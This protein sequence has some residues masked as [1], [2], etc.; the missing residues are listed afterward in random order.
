V[1]SQPQREGG[2]Q[3]YAIPDSV[4]AGIPLSPTGAGHIDTWGILRCP[5]QESGWP[6]I[7]PVSDKI[8]FTHDY[9]GGLAIIVSDAEVHDRWTWS[10]YFPGNPLEG[11]LPDVTCWM[12][13]RQ[14]GEPGNPTGDV[15]L[16]TNCTPSGQLTY[17]QTYPSGC[18]CGFGYG[19]EVPV[20]GWPPQFELG[21]WT[22]VVDYTDPYG[23]TT[24]AVVQDNMYMM[25]TPAVLLIHG[26]EAD[27]DNLLTLEQ[28]LEEELAV[29]NDRVTCFDYN[30]RK[31]RGDGRLGS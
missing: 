9:E 10:Y 1:S 19:A 27:C 21:T 30:S 23:V 25:H 15:A 29:T 13:I 8:L 14:P 20:A 4:P 17:L 24:P 6:C 5:S 11:G 12:H 3:A 2:L 22:A 31:G 7:F 18:P 28:N 16:V 26:W